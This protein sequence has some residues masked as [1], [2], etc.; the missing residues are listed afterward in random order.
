MARGGAGR[1]LSLR[2]EG[3]KER[4]AS[5][6]LSPHR[7]HASLHTPQL[8]DHSKVQSLE[9]LLLR[10]ISPPYDKAYQYFDPNRLPETPL[11]API[12]S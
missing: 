7:S 6:Q 12:Q 1:I 10:L 2:H 8:L 4:T 3:A 5:A 11:S 9:N